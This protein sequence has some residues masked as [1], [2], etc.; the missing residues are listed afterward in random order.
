MDRHDIHYFSSEMGKMELRERLTKFNM[1]LKDWDFTAKERV[2]DFA[3][4]IKP[5]AINIIDFLE[6][7]E[8][9]FNIG[10]PI[11][12]IFDKLDKGIA[13]IA[14]QKNKGNEYGVGGARSIEKAR[15]YL[16]IESDGIE[17]N[18]IKIAKGKNWATHENPN[19]L[20]LEFKLFK[21]CQFLEESGWKEPY[22]P[23]TV[24][25]K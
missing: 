16:T 24:K 21:G 1:P 18:K 13:I 3:D 7:Y 11:K 6:I 10:K 5:D 22:K 8:D 9:F 20:E 14:I 25:K 17:M 4:V 2:A 15:L 19:C 12:E 23:N